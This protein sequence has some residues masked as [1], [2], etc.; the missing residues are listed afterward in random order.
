[1]RPLALGPP[2][3][4]LMCRPVVSGVLRPNLHTA[5][6]LGLQENAGLPCRHFLGHARDT[7]LVDAVSQQRFIPEALVVLVPK[8][9]WSCGPRGNRGTSSKAS[10]D[11]T[12]E[13][14]VIVVESPFCGNFLDG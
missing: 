9:S 8:P 1:M 4:P 10:H 7:R 13:R 12:T 3:C 14:K 2:A 5:L 6:P 11:D